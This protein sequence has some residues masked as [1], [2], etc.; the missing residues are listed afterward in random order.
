MKRIK[1]T[2]LSLLLAVEFAVGVSTGVTSRFAAQIFEPGQSSSISSLSTCQVS[3]SL[4][5]LT[6]WVSLQ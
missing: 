2:Y 6:D 1:L 4:F 5:L 3:L